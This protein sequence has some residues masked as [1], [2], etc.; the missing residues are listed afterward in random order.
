MIGEAAR[1]KDRIARTILDE[2]GFFL[3]AWLGGMIS[4]LDPE[5]IVIGGGVSQ[6]GK[7]LFDKIRETIPEYTIHRRFVPTLPIVPAKLQR[8]VGIFGAASLFLPPAE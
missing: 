6:I 1:R 3:G 7:S 4:L 5:V 8:D 2:T